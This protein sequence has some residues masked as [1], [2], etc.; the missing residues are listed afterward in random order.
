MSH[1]L[2]GG[3]KSILARL[4]YT[5]TLMLMG[6]VKRELINS[7]LLMHEM[8]QLGPS[9]LWLLNSINI[10]LERKELDFIN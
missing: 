4:A 2:L 10:E 5:K 1:T 8:N 3:I 7:L 6:N 9:N